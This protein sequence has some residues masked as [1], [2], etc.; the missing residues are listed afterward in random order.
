VGSV[1]HCRQRC[2]ELMISRAPASLLQ[3]GA[4]NFNQGLGRCARGWHRQRRADRRVRLRVQCPQPVGHWQQRS[5]FEGAADLVGGD[6]INLSALDPTLGWVAI[7]SLRSS[8]R[9]RSQPP[10]N[11]ESARGDDTV[12]QANTNAN[13]SKLKF[14]LSSPLTAG[15]FVF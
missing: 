4:E 15:D 11:C 6:T 13:T 12:I 7:R 2:S 14:E 3:S 1:R 9:P 8:A 5:H 10:V